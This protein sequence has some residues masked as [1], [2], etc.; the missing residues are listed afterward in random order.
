M[1]ATFSINTVV[2]SVKQLKDDPNYNLAG[3]LAQ[4]R[5]STLVLKKVSHDIY[6]QKIFSAVLA[7]CV[8]S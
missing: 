3:R 7:V 6:L 8:A 2:R 5:P 1:N 4:N